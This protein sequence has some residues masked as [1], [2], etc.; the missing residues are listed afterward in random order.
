MRKLCGIVIIIF[1][2]VLALGCALLF[3]EDIILSNIILWIIS[4]PLFISGQ[5][6]RTSKSEFKYRGK[7]W[8]SIYIFF[9][10]IFPLLIY[11]YGYYN[12]LK[13][14]TFVDEQFI[15][16][17]PTSGSLGDLSLVVFMIL[18]SLFAGRFLNPDLKRKGLLN[19]LIIVTIIFLIG[20]NYFMFSDYRGIH[21]EKGLVCSNWKGERHIISYEEIESVYVEP[22]V[23]YARLSSTSDETRFAWKMTFQTNNQKN[24]VVYHFPIMSVFGLE[25][26]MDMEK[27]SM[28]NDIPFIIGEMSQESLKWFDLDLEL[29]GL[30]KER[31]YELFHVNN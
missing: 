27:V 16:Y 12:D 23:H 17:Q 29:E 11:L 5:I 6:I 1:S 7:R 18:I 26:T 31:Y 8:V 30:D 9:F 15:I 24:E 4:L 2:L 3:Q 25:Q 14:N 21:E 19:V 22:Y 28:E 13:E 20:F 10:F